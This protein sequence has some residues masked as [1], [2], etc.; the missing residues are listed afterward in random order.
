MHVPGDAIDFDGRK[1]NRG[2]HFLPNFGSK[3][4][5]LFYFLPSKSIASP[6]S[7]H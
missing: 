4:G 7:A 2:H 1:W 6:G 3:W 5:P